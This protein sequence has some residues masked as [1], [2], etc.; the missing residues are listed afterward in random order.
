MPPVFH[1]ETL[2]IR[3][4]SSFPGIRLQSP[5]SLRMSIPL[6][7]ALLGFCIGI[8][9]LCIL[10]SVPKSWALFLWPVTTC[11]CM[12]NGQNLSITPC[13][14]SGHCFENVWSSGSGL[15]H[16][17]FVH[18]YL[19]LS[20]NMHTLP[21]QKNIGRFTTICDQKTARFDAFT[22]FPCN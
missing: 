19:P 14:W 21:R 2:L 20:M 15:L 5:R 1:L 4:S 9:P 22:C 13:H 17:D 7:F 16:Y 12:Q 11:F 18:I 6:L 10:F 3:I 8:S